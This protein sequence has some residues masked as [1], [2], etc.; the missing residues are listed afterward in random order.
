MAIAWLSVLQLVPW[1]DVISNAPKIADGAKKL[2]S[3]AA[4]RPAASDVVV[5][6]GQPDLSPQ[7]QAVATLQAHLAAAE[8]ALADLQAQ[9]L[10]SSELIKALADQNSQLIQRVESNR[11]RTLWLSAVV[12]VIGAIAVASLV[13]VLTR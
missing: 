7:A 8:V 3:A 4:R 10:A 1:G 5:A 12:A 11:I 13:V 2:W 6:S 9:M